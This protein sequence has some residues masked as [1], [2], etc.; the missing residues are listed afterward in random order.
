LIEQLKNFIKIIEFIVLI[1]MKT[2]ILMTWKLDFFLVIPNATSNFMTNS[3]YDIYV[4][5]RGIFCFIFYLIEADF[6]CAACA[7]TAKC[8]HWLKVFC[9][10]M[11]PISSWKNE[12]DIYVA[13]EKLASEILI[14]I[15]IT[16]NI[17][18]RQKSYQE[19]LEIKTNES[20]HKQ[21]G[22]NKSSNSS[23]FKLA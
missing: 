14:N 10:L 21:I 7:V 20:L 19:E 1:L 13:Y 15:F 18:F 16:E 9:E 6:S 2:C 4:I 12:S 8:Y 17:E 3:T 11:H 23:K 22:L 5:S